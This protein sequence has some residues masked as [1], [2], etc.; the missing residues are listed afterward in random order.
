MVAWKLYH[1]P[2]KS[3]TY[4][5]TRLCSFRI[6]LSRRLLRPWQASPNKTRNQRILRKVVV[7]VYSGWGL[8]STTSLLSLHIVVTV[9]IWKMT[10]LRRSLQSSPT[11]TTQI[12][13]AAFSRSWA[14]KMPAVRGKSTAISDSLKISQRRAERLSRGYV[15]RKTSS[16]LERV[17][18]R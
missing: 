14:M 1:P 16:W 12:K 15:S 11:V 2:L 13:W 10:K 18:K 4:G 3:Q 9:K 6:V 8:Q 7:M 5:E 17:T